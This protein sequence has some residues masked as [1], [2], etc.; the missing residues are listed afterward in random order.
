M[1]LTET[2]ILISVLPFSERDAV[3]RVFTRRHGVLAGMVKAGLTSK[4]RGNLQ[5]GNHV[6]LQWH[7]RLAEQLGTMTL[8]MLHPVAAR[9]MGHADKLQAMLSA[10]A[11]IERY[12]GEREAHLETMHA[13]ENLLEALMGSGAGWLALYVRFED[14]LLKDAGFGL[15]LE[16]CAATGVRENLVYIS[17]KSGCAVSATAGEPYAQKLFALPELLKNPA[18]HEISVAQTID[19]LRMTGYFLEARL[20]AASGRELPAARVRWL[21]HLEKSQRAAS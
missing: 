1:Q 8:E 13:L 17:P 15:D 11:L 21:Q 7:A 6:Q 18:I 4:Q 12:F 3:C 5:V 9:V 10:C 2:G 16:Q 19:A 14:A 20:V